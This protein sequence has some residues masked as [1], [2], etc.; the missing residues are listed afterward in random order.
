MVDFN[1]QSTIAT[2]AVNVERISILEARVNTFLALEEYNTKKFNGVNMSI[3]IVRSRLITWF[4]FHQPY[5][6][7]AFKDDDQIVFYNK[8]L[9]DLFDEELL[10]DTTILRYVTF[11]NEICD[12][13]RITRLDNF[14]QIDTLDI[15]AE[16]EAE[17]V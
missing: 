12:S 16:N 17:G 13:L 11:L 1:N 7:R 8:M 2:P 3:S 15:E 4:L 6:K 5:L 10:D 14:K 9:K